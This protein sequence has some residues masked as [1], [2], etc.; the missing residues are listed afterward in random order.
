MRHLMTFL[1]FYASVI[2]FYFLCKRIFKSWKYG[3]TGSCFL[4]VSPRIFADSFYNSKDLVFLSVFIVAIYTLILLLDKKTLRYALL[5]GVVSALVINIRILGILIPCFTIALLLLFVNTAAVR[6]SRIPQFKKSVL[7]IILYIGACAVFTVLFWPWLWEQPL[8]H[9]VQ[10][11]INM[12]RFRWDGP[13]LYLGHYIPATKLPWHYIPVW[14]IVT[15]PLA[16]T[17]LFFAGLFS[18]GKI[19]ISSLRQRRCELHIHQLI[20]LMWFFIPL[21]AIIL[22]R[23]V[24]YDGWRHLYFIYPGFLLL[25]MTGL[26]YIAKSP[27]RTLKWQGK[28][29]RASAYCLIILNFFSTVYLMVACHPHQYVYFNLLAGLDGESIRKNYELDYWGLSYRQGLEYIAQSDS[30]QK[31]RI[32]FLPWVGMNNLAILPE[33]DRKRLIQTD[34]RSEADYLIGNFRWPNWQKE[35]PPEDKEVYSIKVSGIK[36]L[37]V[38]R[39]K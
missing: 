38:Y 11:F 32:F 20:I 34:D 14:M 24:V 10:A 6:N 21:C 28:V 29:F 19:I 36:I 39:L 35:Y 37:A 16:Y 1:V 25:A 17:F 18:L 7:L 5:H 15:T 31:I 8:S 2:I 3:I 23:S 9:F 4:V 27:W 26:G 30:R 12:T 13:V 33:A 22:L